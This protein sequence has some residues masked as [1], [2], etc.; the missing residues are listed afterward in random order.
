[1]LKYLTTYMQCALVAGAVSVLVVANAKDQG[2]RQSL[3]DYIDDNAL[4]EETQLRIVE[5]SESSSINDTYDNFS[6]RPGDWED[7]VISSQ[8]KA[9]DGSEKRLS[10]Y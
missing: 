10:L 4:T 1:M 5:P 7:Y 2:F 3:L 9:S 6:Y 8:Y